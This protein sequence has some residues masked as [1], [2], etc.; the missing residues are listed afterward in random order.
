MDHV[1][2]HPFI[3]EEAHGAGGRP[4]DAARTQ[5]ASQD[6][7]AVSASVR[8]HVRELPAQGISHE[9]CPGR[10]KPA[11]GV[12]EREVYPVRHAGQDPVGEPRYGVLLLYGA[13]AA[14]DPAGQH[15]HA[16]DVAARADDPVGPEIPD[17]T[18]RLEERPGVDEDRPEKVR[19]GLALDAQRSDPDEVQA[20]EPGDPLFHAPVSAHEEDARTGI[21]GNDGLG[22]GHCRHD[23]APCSPGR[24][25]HLHRR[26]LLDTDRI[27]PQ[28]HMVLSRAEP[29]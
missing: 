21:A 1:R 8:A 17:D 24:D 9:P 13:G 11:Q 16:R 23:V 14:R 19:H 20:L 22:D 2:R 5:A 18:E 27:T 7:Q 28:M 29:P 12:R 6:K 10:G 3:P 4:V 15:H 25:E 26:A